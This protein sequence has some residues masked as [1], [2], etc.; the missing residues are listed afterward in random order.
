MVRYKN[1]ITPIQ[2][3]QDPKFV[4]K[5]LTGPVKHSDTFHFRIDISVPHLNA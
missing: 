3:L 1:V 2:F 4:I 5:W